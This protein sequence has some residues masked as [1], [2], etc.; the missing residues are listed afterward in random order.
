MDPAVQAFIDKWAEKSAAKQVVLAAL[1]AAKLADWKAENALT[2][3]DAKP[4]LAEAERQ[5]AIVEARGARSGD[6]GRAYDEAF[7]LAEAFVEAHPELVAVGAAFV[8]P[9]DATA[10]EKNTKH[11]LL[12]TLIAEAGKRGDVELATKLT[13]FELVSFE[14]QHI[15]QALA[16][17][18]RRS[19]GR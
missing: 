10:D 4:H 9:D 3:A 14:R 17:K 18:V 7:A 13:M 5:W 12:V 15:G 19:N 2:P 11:Q 16:V 1:G 8:A 6:E